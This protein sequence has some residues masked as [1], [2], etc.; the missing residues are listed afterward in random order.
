[1]HTIESLCTFLHSARLIY[2]AKICRVWECSVAAMFPDISSSTVGATPPDLTCAIKLYLILYPIVF[3]TE[4]VDYLAV[5][6]SVVEDVIGDFLL[7][8]RI[9]FERIAYNC[10]DI[11]GGPCFFENTNYSRIS[12]LL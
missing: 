12:L 8:C 11:D 4:I 7:L 2:G 6:H 10:L 5:D 3:E 9:L 1:M